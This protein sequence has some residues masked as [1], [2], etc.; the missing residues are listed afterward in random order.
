M[1]ALKFLLALS[2]KAEENIKKAGWRGFPFVFLFLFFGHW[3]AYLNTQSE[4]LSPTS[5]QQSYILNRLRRRRLSTS[6]GAAH[7]APTR[8]TDA[9]WQIQHC[10]TANVGLACQ[11]PDSKKRWGGCC[12]QTTLTLDI[13]L[14]THLQAGRPALMEMQISAVLGWHAASS[15]VSTFVSSWLHLPPESLVLTLHKG[16]AHFLELTDSSSLLG[17]WE[18]HHLIFP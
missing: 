5:C 3:S 14:K 17:F 6:N 1:S 8:A 18:W 12:F 16:W 15:W 10:P 4:F 7:I 11:G 2:K 9:H 13:Y